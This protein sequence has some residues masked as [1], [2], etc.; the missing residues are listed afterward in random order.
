M[1]TDE[2]AI[3][4]SREVTICNKKLKEIEKFLAKMEKKYHMTTEAFLKEYATGEKTWS[5]DFS[6][7]KENHEALKRWRE[8][9]VQYDEAYRMM[10]T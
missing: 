1:H 6:A 2:Y 10:K 8:L 4:L 9:K 3:T 5:R 7:W